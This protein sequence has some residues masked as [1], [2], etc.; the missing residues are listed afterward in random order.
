MIEYL[1]GITVSLIVVPV[2]VYLSVKLGTYGYLKA[3]QRFVDQQRDLEKKV[4]H[5]SEST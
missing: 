5:G 1:V 2:L 3:H 4:N